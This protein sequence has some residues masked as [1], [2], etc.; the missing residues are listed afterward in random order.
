M[1]LEAGFRG[2]CDPICIIIPV[3]SLWSRRDGY[4]ILVLLVSSYCAVLVCECCRL[5]T[6]VMN[7]EELEEDH[8]CSRENWMLRICTAVPFYCVQVSSHKAQRWFIDLSPYEWSCRSRL[9]LSKRL[10]CCQCVCDGAGIRT[11][12]CHVKSYLVFTKLRPLEGASLT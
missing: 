5:F 2:G 4:Y 1:Q 8:I 10:F 9:M 12:H 7:P 11:I 6:F 3:L